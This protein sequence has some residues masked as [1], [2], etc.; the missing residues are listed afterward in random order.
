[1][2]IADLTATT[3]EKKLGAV[4]RKTKPRSF[5][6]KYIW[7]QNI[8]S[9]LVH[10]LPPPKNSCISLSFSDPFVGAAAQ[11]FVLFRPAPRS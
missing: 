11:M 3:D 9:C 2:Q 10:Q 4:L 8:G 7:E 6:G 1:M 5:E